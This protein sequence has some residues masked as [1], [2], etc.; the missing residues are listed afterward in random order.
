M[1]YRTGSEGRAVAT[2]YPTV[3]M[4]VFLPSVLPT[5]LG[6]SALL[7]GSPEARPLQTAE[8]AIGT[9]K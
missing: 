7:F 6:S 2:P 4:I 1:D 5:S 8:L 3:I 9:V